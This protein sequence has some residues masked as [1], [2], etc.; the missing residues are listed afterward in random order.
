MLSEFCELSKEEEKY[1]H[2]LDVLDV[3]EQA[4]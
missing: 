4:P 2:V 1:P 3:F